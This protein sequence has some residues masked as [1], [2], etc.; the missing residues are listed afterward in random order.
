MKNEK[1]W[2]GFTEKINKSEEINN[3]KNSESIQQ[4]KEIMKRLNSR[5]TKMRLKIIR[6]FE[7]VY[8][9]CRTFSFIR[10]CWTG[11]MNAV[12]MVD[13]TNYVCETDQMEVRK[14]LRQ[15]K[16]KKRSRHDG[17]SNE[18]FKYYLNSLESSLWEH[19]EIVRKLFISLYSWKVF[20]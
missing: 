12:L 15:M 9:V 18:N 6:C 11:K 14:L 8:S 5:V 3:L 4:K 1:Y 16:N 19:L 10:R 13:I 7:W 20:K 2:N 17:K